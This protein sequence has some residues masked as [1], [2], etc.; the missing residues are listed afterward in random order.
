MATERELE[1]LG[2]PVP[3]DPHRLRLLHLIL[4]REKAAAD[5]IDRT[6]EL[7]TALLLQSAEDNRIAPSA[8]PVIRQQAIKEFGQL[9]VRL[10][11]QLGDGIRQAATL[12]ADSFENTGLTETELATLAA[13]VVA[14]VT[15]LGFKGGFAISG[16]PFGA[17]LNRL[18]I[19]T[20]ASLLKN[21]TRAALLDASVN[22]ITQQVRTELAPT[23]KGVAASLLPNVV[24]V[25]RDDYTSAY[26]ESQVAL[27]DRLKKDIKFKYHVS[28]AYNPKR[29][30]SIPK[31][32][33][34]DGQIFDAKEAAAF[35]P[36]HSHCMCWWEPLA[37]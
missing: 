15:D 24:R 20:Q 22:G 21:V 30:N 26:A 3:T 31:C 4:A 11:N 28:A 29:C 25:V 34:F 14:G 1:Q 16:E 17:H 5:E 23:D 19:N 8:V 6:I 35:I 36:R 32:D 33:T 10:Q 37:E 2:L 9:S 27:A 18:T 12:G 7:L 13:A